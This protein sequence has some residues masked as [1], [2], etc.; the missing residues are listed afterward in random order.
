MKVRAARLLAQMWTMTSRSGSKYELRPTRIRTSFEV[1][2]RVGPCAVP[3]RAGIW[4]GRRLGD[5]AGLL[6]CDGGEDSPPPPGI[7]AKLPKD[8]IGDPNEL[9]DWRFPPWKLCERRASGL[10]ED[11]VFPAGLGAVLP[12]SASGGGSMTLTSPR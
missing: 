3:G 5:G 4:L 6:S 8:A 12:P 9:L 1:A 10:A 11:S 2:S 7:R